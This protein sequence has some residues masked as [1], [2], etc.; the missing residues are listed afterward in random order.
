MLGIAK[1]GDVGHGFCEAGHDTDNLKPGEPKEMT[2]TFVSGD[3]T[4]FVN[5]L[6]VCTVG[7]IGQT[8]CQDKGEYHTTTAISGSSTVFIGNQGVH[9][10]G[11][12]GIIN[13]ENNQYN[14][15]YTVVSGSTDVFIG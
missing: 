7:T 12:T 11:D 6:P 4:V 9:R 15:E 13:E 14:G 10:V 3:T 1:I 8:D 5:Y 2:T